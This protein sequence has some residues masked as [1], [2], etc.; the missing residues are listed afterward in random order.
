MKRTR[1][2]RKIVPLKPL[3]SVNPSDEIEHGPGDTVALIRPPKGRHGVG[4]IVAVFNDLIIVQIPLTDGG[5]RDTFE[6]WHCSKTRMVKHGWRRERKEAIWDTASAVRDHFYQLLGVRKIDVSDIEDDAERPA[7]T[8]ESMRGMLPRL[9]AAMELLHQADDLIHSPVDTCD[10]IGWNWCDGHQAARVAAFI[11][12]G[13]EHLEDLLQSAFCA[14]TVR[15]NDD[16]V[17]QRKHAVAGKE[18]RK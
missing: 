15:A 3:D 13:Q 14:I 8:L 9:W 6:A 11:Q 2:N 4:T 16:L 18:D 7:V 17:Q 1:T 10:T 5:K 12:R